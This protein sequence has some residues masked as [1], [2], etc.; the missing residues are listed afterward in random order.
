MGSPTNSK[1]WLL[2]NAWMEIKI[3]GNNKTN[4]LEDNLGLFTIISSVTKDIG[5]ALIFF[6]VLPNNHPEISIAGIEMIMPKPNVFPISAPGRCIT[7]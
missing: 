7:R 4:K 3:T 6:K 1:N 5:L 2:A